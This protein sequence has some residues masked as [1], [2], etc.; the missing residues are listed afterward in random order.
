MTV[1]AL[2]EWLD[3]DILGVTLLEDIQLRHTSA[4]E[5]GLSKQFGF[6]FDKGV[7]NSAYD[8][9]GCG[10]GTDCMGQEL[11]ESPIEDIE[12]VY[13]WTYPDADNPHIFYGVPDQIEQIHR[14][15]YAAFVKQ[16]YTLFERAWAMTGYTEFLMACYTDE[17]AVD[18][19]LDKI[20]ENK[21]RIAE[22][23]CALNPEVGHTS[24]DF[25]LQ[26]GGVMSL[27]MFRRF[28]KPRLEKFGTSIKNMEYRLCITAAAIA[29][30]IFL[31]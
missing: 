12:D 5:F 28:F 18:F 16:N 24:D 3:G 14:D 10:W 20:T 29:A 15:G 22:R 4:E 1:Q 13:D 27:E 9:W 8:G 23:I 21:I 11:R 26:K 19:L 2:R 17:D 31:I 25:G 30:C 6:V 7:P